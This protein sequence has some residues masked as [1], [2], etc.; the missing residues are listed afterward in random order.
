MM[1]ATASR[2]RVV[3]WRAIEALLLDLPGKPYRRG[4]RGPDAFSCWGLVLEVRRRLGMPAPP[5]I[6]E[7]ALTPDETRA[8]FRGLRPAG[9]RQVDPALGAIVL[10]PDASH[11]GVLVAH[12]VLHVQARAGVVAWSLGQWVAHYG[13]LDCWE[14]I[15]RMGG[16]HG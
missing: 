10:A 12:R 5:D 8:L 14:V 2:R 7:E 16:A 13:A 11:S 15:E 3:D 9:W 4:A 1:A 6:A